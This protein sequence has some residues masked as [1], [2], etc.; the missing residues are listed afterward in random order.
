MPGIPVEVEPVTAF[1]ELHIGARV[2][3]TNCEMCGA[4][5][6]H[7]IVAMYVGEYRSFDDEILIGVAW[8]VAADPHGEDDILFPADGLRDLYRE[9]DQVMDAERDTIAR[10]HRLAVRA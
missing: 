5:H 10:L 1:G 8:E 7:F 9:V 6:Q 3:E 4:V 2:W